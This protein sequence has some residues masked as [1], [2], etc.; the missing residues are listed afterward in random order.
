MIDTK[1]SLKDPAS[2]SSDCLVVFW[3][4]KKPSGFLTQLDSLLNGAVSAQFSAGRFEGKAGQTAVLYAGDSLGA[5]QVI[6]TGTGKNKDIKAE[7]LRNAAG[8]A[9]KVAEKSKCKQV[10]LYFPESDFGKLPGL[11]GQGKEAVTHAIVEGAQLALYHF[12]SY[13]TPDEKIRRRA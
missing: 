10:A 6:L 8:S 9:V 4:E 5:E 11:K 2:H 12:D 1:V 3:P 13:K 7:C